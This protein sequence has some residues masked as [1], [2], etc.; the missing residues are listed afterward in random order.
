LIYGGGTL[1]ASQDW[2]FPRM[3]KDEWGPIKQK[4]KVF[5]PG[6]RTQLKSRSNIL[7][8]VHFDKGPFD[9]ALMGTIKV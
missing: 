5:G 2:T 6:Q 4:P 1:N 7:K 3:G 9:E 8:Q